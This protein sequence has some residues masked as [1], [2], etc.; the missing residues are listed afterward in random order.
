MAWNL[1]CFLCILRGTR[2][3]WRLSPLLFALAAE[4]LAMWLLNKDRYEGKVRYSTTYK[5]SFYADDLLLYISNP[6]HSM[7][8]IVNIREEF[9]KYS[10]Y[11]IN[12]SKSDYIPIDPSTIALPQGFFLF[13]K[14]V[15]G[16]K[17]P[18]IQ[19]TNSFSELFSKN[20][21]FLCE[22]CK[23]DLSRWSTLPLSLMGRTNLIKMIVLLQFLNLF[24]HIPILI[25]KSLFSK[26]D[27]L[28]S[29]FL[30]GNKRVRYQSIGA[31]SPKSQGRGGAR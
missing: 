4:P 17:Y 2:Q 3:G 28:I 8:V 22:Q 6:V 21:S 27:Q 23:S 15:E 12:N 10:S 14:A 16:L 1:T 29:S 13:R 9:G 25:R 19:V 31:L 26:L 30:W 7:P 11:K 5:T 24:R 18:G 20:Y